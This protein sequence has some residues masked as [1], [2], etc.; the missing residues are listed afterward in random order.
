LET[1]SQFYIAEAVPPN[2]RV[3]AADVLE[4]RC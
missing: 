3:K 4:N 1:P 2:R